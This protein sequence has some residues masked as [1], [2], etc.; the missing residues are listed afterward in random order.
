MEAFWQARL[1]PQDRIRRGFSNGCFIPSII[2]LCTSEVGR[3][4]PL[5][6]ASAGHRLVDPQTTVATGNFGAA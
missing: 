3:L 5:A 2:A 4:E 1:Q 6:D